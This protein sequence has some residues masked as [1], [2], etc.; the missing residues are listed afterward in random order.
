MIM[1]TLKE[2]KERNIKIV[3]IAEKI[4][5]S[6]APITVAELVRDYDNGRVSFDNAMQ[7]GCVWDNDKCSLF[8]HSLLTR[9]P[10]YPVAGVRNEGVLD[11]LDGK[12]RMLVAAINFVKNTY[13]LKN[14]DP[15]EI[16][17]E[18]GSVDTLDING[19][20]FEDLPE[21]CQ[22]II[23]GFNFTIIVL[24]ENVPDDKIADMFFRWNNGKP[25]S[26]IELTRVKT[27]SQ[28]QIK[29]MASHDIFTSTMTPKSLAAF[30]N[31]DIVTKT[32]FM[33]HEKEPWLETKHLREEVVKIDITDEE[34]AEI[35][36][37]YDRAMEMR[38]CMKE[39]LMKED[40]KMSEKRALTL[41]GK[42]LNKTHLLS[43]A[44]FIKKTID[45]NLSVEAASSWFLSFF[46]RKNGST[47]AIYNEYARGGSGK[48]HS[49]ARRNSELLK[50]WNEWLKKYRLEEAEK[51][52]EIANAAETETDQEYEVAITDETEVIERDDK[53]PFE[54]TEINVA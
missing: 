37:I 30:K 41:S 43:T 40:P 19:C 11:I 2:L 20:K 44:L 28:N 12:Q 18:D 24:G 26:A 33:L 4:D 48:K 23:K 7:R 3:D 47:S 6:T 50:H 31:E 10:I 35:V 46:G 45:E 49:I 51:I 52:R 53:L 1:L 34:K 32:Y 42:I 25:L 17:L 27:K 13:S 8:I 29:E 36:S 22:D 16:T 14:I 54:T 9:V 15:I 5:Q 39:M 21:T 38:V